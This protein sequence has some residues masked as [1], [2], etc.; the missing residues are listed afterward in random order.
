MPGIESF[1]HVSL[2]LVFLRVGSRVYVQV[3]VSVASRQH[4]RATTLYSSEAEA[5]MSFLL[6]HRLSFLAVHVPHIACPSVENSEVS[7]STGLQAKTDRK[8]STHLLEDSSFLS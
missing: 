1:F 4:S 8:T 3:V 2:Y 5:S 6:H 7:V